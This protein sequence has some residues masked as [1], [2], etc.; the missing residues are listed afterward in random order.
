[1]RKAAPKRRKLRRD[2]NPSLLIGMIGEKTGCGRG[3]FGFQSDSQET[4]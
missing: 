1:M 4:Y 2:E 3:I